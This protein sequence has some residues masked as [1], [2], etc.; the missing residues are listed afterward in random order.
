LRKTCFVNRFIF[1]NLIFLLNYVS[2]G[3]ENGLAHFWMTDS[4]QLTVSQV[5]N[6]PPFEIISLAGAI[7]AALQI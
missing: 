5:K 2:V 6:Q 1:A 3:P 4:C 7:A